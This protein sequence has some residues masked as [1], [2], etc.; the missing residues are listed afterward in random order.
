M[1][2]PKPMEGQPFSPFWFWQPLETIYQTTSI[3]QANHKGLHLCFTAAQLEENTVTTD[4]RYDP[5]KNR[6]KH[7]KQVS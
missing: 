1:N 3:I 5:P 6:N 7:Q 2:I 4:N